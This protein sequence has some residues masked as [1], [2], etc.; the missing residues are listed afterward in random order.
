MK[1]FKLWSNLMR[2]HITEFYP[3]WHGFLHDAE[4]CPT[5][6]SKGALKQMKYNGFSAWDLSRDLWSFVG[7]FLGP[8][9][10]LKRQR[11]SKR[12]FGNGFEFWRQLFK[13]YHGGVP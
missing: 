8:K 1:D 13:D 5:P 11:L 6:I 4:L 12:A 7:K 3:R 9:L 10:Y 2:D